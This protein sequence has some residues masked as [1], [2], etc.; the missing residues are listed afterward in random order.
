MDVEQNSRG[1]PETS[2]VPGGSSRAQQAMPETF[3]SGHQ[4]VGVVALDDK[5]VA[6]WWHLSKRT[7]VC[8]VIVTIV[9][10][11]AVV[12]VVLGMKP[13]SASSQGS[14]SASTKDYAL[15]YNTIRTSLA[16]V[17]D[18]VSFVSTSSP[19]S[20]ALDWLVYKDDTLTSVD[21]PMTESTTALL[22]QRYA[23]MVMQFALKSNWQ[24]DPLQTPFYRLHEC[25]FEGITCNADQRITRFDW[26]SKE[27]AGAIPNEISLLTTMNYLDLN[28]NF[29][30]GSIPDALYDMTALRKLSPSDAILR[31]T[32]V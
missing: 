5:D 26:Q 2:G 6:G 13:R 18:S 15:R 16:G 3:A 30:D 20:Q 25:D 22:I 8:I 28:S 19:Q 10:I 31:G 11:G 21:G 1:Q 23:V 27:L 9:V 32:R 29:I 17:T 14:S 4:S 7:A 24:N 12:G